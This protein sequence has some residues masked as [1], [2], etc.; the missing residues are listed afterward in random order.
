MSN[1]DQKLLAAFSF[2]LG[3]CRGALT[4][5][6]GAD[7]RAS[8]MVQRVLDGTSLQSICNAIDIEVPDIDWN[9]ELS[10][11]ER[12]AIENDCHRLSTSTTEQ[13]DEP[14]SR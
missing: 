14:K 13:S 3:L 10:G 5:L 7:S 11:T 6:Q 9:N 1:S 8:Q 12:K 4:E 2:A